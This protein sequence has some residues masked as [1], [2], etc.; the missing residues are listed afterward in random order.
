M[1]VL[2]FQFEIHNS[3]MFELS[4]AINLL[5]KNQSKSYCSDIRYDK[6]L[7]TS[8]N[9]KSEYLTKTKYISNNYI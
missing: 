1:L 9:F 5:F 8:I 7:N 2:F 3:V 6:I 4:F